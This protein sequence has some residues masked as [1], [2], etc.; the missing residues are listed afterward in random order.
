M[1]GVEAG[2]HQDLRYLRQR[3]SAGKN[4]PPGVNGWVPEEGFQ[5][6]WSVFYR[7]RETA[8]IK[9]P[10]ERKQWVAEASDSR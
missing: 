4:R 9:G 3:L 7:F 6:C 1:I 5:R 10:R 8:G 2:S